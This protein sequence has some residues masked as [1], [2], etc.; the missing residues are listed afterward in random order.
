MAAEER[1]ARGRSRKTDARADRKPIFERLQPFAPWDQRAATALLDEPA[2]RQ[3]AGQLGAG[4]R[5]VSEA[6]AG[7]ADA[8]SSPTT[9][10]TLRHLAEVSSWQVGIWITELGGAEHETSRLAKACEALD[11]SDELVAL[12]LLGRV[13]LPHLIADAVLFR[14]QLGDDLPKSHRRWL[15]I[16]VEDLEEQR[17]ELELLVQSAVGDA[18]VERVVRACGGVAKTV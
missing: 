13:V 9:S 11:P 10:A 3:R 5:A 2:A 12:A 1:P 16:L 7:L 8:A 15:S 6:A 4:M 18:D 17:A 14:A